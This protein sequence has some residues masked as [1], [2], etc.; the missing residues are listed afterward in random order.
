MSRNTKIILAVG[1]A[2]FVL[3]ID[4]RISVIDSRFLQP[5][6]SGFKGLILYEFGGYQEAARAYRAHR[7]KEFLAGRS[8][9]SPARDAFLRGD[10]KTAKHVISQSLAKKPN[11][12]PNLL[13]MGEIE[14]DAKNP[15]QALNRFSRVLQISSQNREALLW[16]AHAHTQMDQY[17]KAID[18]LKMALSSS[19][20]GKWEEGFLHLPQ[21]M[22]SCEVM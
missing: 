12:I 9:G 17:G 13:L 10:V 15:D 19:A 1:L 22:P 5:S 8:S 16:S 3:W 21:E 11:S 18:A 2:V 6:F 20:K 14:L 4:H 7:Q